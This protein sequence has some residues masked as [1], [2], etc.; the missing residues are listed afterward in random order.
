[1]HRNALEGPEYNLAGRS[2]STVREDGVSN[3]GD[4]GIFPAATGIL[5]TGASLRRGR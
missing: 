3:M 2:Q 1:M 4:W 5:P